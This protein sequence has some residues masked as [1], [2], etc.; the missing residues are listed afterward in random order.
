MTD[1]P[2]EPTK[3]PP[4]RLVSSLSDEE[5]KAADREH[6]ARFVLHQVEGALCRLSANIMRVARGTGRAD[7]IPEQI[8]ACANAILEYREVAGRNPG[9]QELAD[10]LRVGRDFE[11]FD[12]RASD[13]EMT[14]GTD[15]I[16]RGILQVVAS[17][18]LGQ[19]T[20]ES[21]GRREM[22]DGIRRIE[23][24]RE[25]N[26]RQ[27]QAEPPFSSRQ[28]SPGREATA[29]LARAAARAAKSKSPKVKGARAANAASPPR[30]PELPAREQPAPAAPQAAPQ[31]ARKPKAKSVA[32]R[33]AVLAAYKASRGIE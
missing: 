7:E 15:E 13:A 25:A 23:Q 27:R 14:I 6:R 18:M 8:F 33:K 1:D 10:M 22:F 28:K 16:L 21:A 31:P 4:M 30:P 29:A 19:R 26:R 17:R 24:Y 12:W 5:A 9:D 11:N 32:G 20:Q 3:H 2:D